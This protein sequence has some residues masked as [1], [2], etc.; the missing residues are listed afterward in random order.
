MGIDANNLVLLVEVVEF[1]NLRQLLGI[2]GLPGKAK[3]SGVV[4]YDLEALG[5]TEVSHLQ[6]FFLGCLHFLG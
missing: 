4:F 5:F 1:D 2:E 6:E 3:K